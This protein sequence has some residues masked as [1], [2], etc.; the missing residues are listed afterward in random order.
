MCTFTD[1]QDV[2]L[3]L[4]K[5]IRRG[6]GFDAVPGVG[7]VDD[8]G[9]TPRLSECVTADARSVQIARALFF[10]RSP[11]AMADNYGIR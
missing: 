8:T 9:K 11:D 10:R 3:N 7:L 1:R 4:S 5:R 2:Y 6:A